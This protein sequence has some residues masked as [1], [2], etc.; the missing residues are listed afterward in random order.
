MKKIY[1][2]TLCLAMATMVGCDKSGGDNGGEETPA[3]VSADVTY[4]VNDGADMV[5]LF[6]ITVE[7]TDATGTKSEAIASLPWSKSVHVA[8]IPFTASLKVTYVAKSNYAQK[9]VYAVGFGSGI[10]YRTSD[11]QYVNSSGSSNLSVSAA[12]ITEY[13]TKYDGTVKGFT[14]DIALSKKNPNKL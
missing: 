13:I 6:D 9:D 4:S 10:S 2:L 11:G 5:V 14:E 8:K 7:Y 1:F 3:D 12:K